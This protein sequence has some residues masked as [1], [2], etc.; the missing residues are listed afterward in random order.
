LRSMDVLEL[1]NELEDRFRVRVGQ[2]DL[3]AGRLKSVD[4]ILELVGTAP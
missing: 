3:A 2:R 4:A 1:V